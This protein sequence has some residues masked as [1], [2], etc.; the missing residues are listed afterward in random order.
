MQQ[1]QSISHWWGSQTSLCIS[2]DIVVNDPHFLSG[3]KPKVSSGKRGADAN[4]VIAQRID[5]VPTARPTP[6]LGS[7]QPQP[8][9]LRVG[10]WG[11][12]PG[13]IGAG[14]PPTIVSFLNPQPPSR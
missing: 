5:I 6:A 2:W 4:T 3:R 7:L 8:D 1:Y 11:L 9:R 10:L 13:A 14:H 12:G